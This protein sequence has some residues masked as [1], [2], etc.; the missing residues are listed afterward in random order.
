MD[1]PDLVTADSLKRIANV[2]ETMLPLIERI[3]DDMAEFT[4]VQAEAFELMKA[5]EDEMRGAM[6]GDI[7]LDRSVL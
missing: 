1:D 7:Q 2:L 6:A 5:R 3:T 4:R